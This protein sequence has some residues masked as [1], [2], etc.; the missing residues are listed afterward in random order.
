M[1]KINTTKVIFDTW[2]KFNNLNESFIL[3]KNPSEVEDIDEW[4][5]E[6]GFVE[7]DPEK[8][9]KVFSKN[10]DFLDL[11]TGVEERLTMLSTSG[12]N[13]NAKI[14]EIIK[15]LESYVLKE[16]E[17]T[18]DNN[19][20]GKILFFEDEDLGFI[21]F[22]FE[23]FKTKYKNNSVLKSTIEFEPPDRTGRFSF[24]LGAYKILLVHDSTP[25]VN[26]LLYEILLEF[27]SV[28]RNGGVCSDRNS[29][30]P[31]AQ[32]KY[33]IY[34]NRGDVDFV[35]LDIEKKQSEEF[36]Y[37]QLTPDDTSDDIS[38][39]I[40][41]RHMGKDWHKS[42]FSKML[43]KKN[44]NTL[45]YICNQSDLLEIEFSIINQSELT[46]KLV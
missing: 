19:K 10:T 11:D 6:F 34:K 28:V 14:S 31:A 42:I 39:N 23:D 40:S 16:R 45:K 29:I 8:Y 2:R 15:D 12:N 37:P 9:A 38:Q 7:E 4:M 5:T 13:L 30:T 33:L 36:N 32:K 43:V 44:M 24:G 41:I 22:Y 25:G 3:S 20:K 18:G 35:Q 26:A 46:S 21:K 17:V 1:K 27:T